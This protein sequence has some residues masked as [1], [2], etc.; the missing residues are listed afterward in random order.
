MK[1]LHN[2]KWDNEKARHLK[3]RLYVSTGDPSITS[4]RTLKAML[5]D[6]NVKVSGKIYILK[7]YMKKKTLL[8]KLKGYKIKKAIEGINKYSNNFMADISLAKISSLDATNQDLFSNGSK[9]LTQ[10]MIEI[11]GDKRSVLKNSS[12]VF[13]PIIPSLL[14]P[15]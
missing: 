3:D 9:I 1:Q 11:G 14:N 5:N 2:C 12:V 13:Q 7:K 15:T 10:H 8:Y 6:L 4:A